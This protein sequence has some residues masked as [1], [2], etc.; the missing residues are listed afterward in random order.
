[1][2]ADGPTPFPT[3]PRRLDDLLVRYWADDLTGRDL[4]ELNDRLSADPAAVRQLG[5]FCVETMVGAAARPA[6]RPRRVYA[7]LPVALAAGIVAALVV[8]RPADPV[9]PVAPV[10][11]AGEVARVVRSAGTVWVSAAAGRRPAAAGT[12]VGGGETI[13]AEGVASSALV[14]YADGTSV[15]VDAD[16]VATF[17]GASGRQVL[18]R[19]GVV[20]ADIPAG[21][22]GAS[23]AL[24]TPE[25]RAA[26]RARA[27]VSLSRQDDRTEI[28]V[29]RGRV[30]VTA[31]TGDRALDVDEGEVA[32]CSPAGDFEKRDMAAVP[33]AYAWNLSR[34]LPFGWEA[35]RLEPAPPPAAVRAVT[36][37]SPWT[38]RS[39]FQVRSDNA[40]IEGHFALTPDSRVRAKYKVD[41]P[42]AGVLVIVARPDPAQK[43]ACVV[44][45][46]PWSPETARPGVWET[47]DVR[48]GDLIPER[49]PG[50]DPPWVGYLV[51]FNTFDVDLGLRVAEFSVAPPGAPARGP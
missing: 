24:V 4:D 43:S 38:S 5:A 49:P 17:G 16:T 2:P 1:M 34:P 36:W 21:D 9:A 29:T 14:E 50:F 22:A 32:S 10:A 25:A 13:A 27:V 28:G 41:R 18:I 30:R 19:R 12:A 44:L 42:G 20:T 33:P 26:A 48:A 6:P 37:F 7:W 31:P 8:G 46:V 3:D 51:L 23:F 45:N 47:V 35:G 39:E 40:F 11:P 15:G